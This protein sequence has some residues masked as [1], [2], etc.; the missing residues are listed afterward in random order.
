MKTRRGT[1]VLVVG[2]SGAGKDTLIEGASAALAGNPA[3][4]FPR[5]DVTRKAGLGGENYRAVTVDEFLAREA[6]GGYCLSWQAHD[7]H[8]GILREVEDHLAAGRH[9]VANVSR[10][11]IEEARARL[12]PVLVVNIAV[13][14]EVLARRL[15]ARGRE[16]EAEI[17]GRLARAR[18]FA[19]SGPDVAT[20]VSDGPAAETVAR[21]VALLRGLTLPPP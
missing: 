6:A 21:F 12:Q 13:S 10:S 18:A 11:V 2:P 3:F 17:A 4:G 15:R 20:I 19:V 14:E 1:L 16:S 5:R 9:V 8:Y 7:L